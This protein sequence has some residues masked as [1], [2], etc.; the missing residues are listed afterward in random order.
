MHKLTQQGQTKSVIPVIKHGLRPSIAK[1]IVF[2]PFIILGSFALFSALPSTRT[3]SLWMVKEDGPVELLT[4][5]FLVAGAITGLCL[6]WQTRNHKEK[7]FV[8]A[9][10]LLFSTGLLFTA[11]EEIAWGQRFLGFETPS[12]FRQINAQNELT[13]HNIYALQ[14]HSEFF[15]LAFGVGGLLGM[16]LSFHPVLRKVGVPLILCSWFLII[17]VHAS[18]DTYNDYF[19]IGTRFDF[20]MQR[21]S[22][23]IELLIGI[24][25]FLYLWL[26]LRMLTEEW[27]LGLR[28][29]AKREVAAA[30]LD[31]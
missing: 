24:S 4:F 31:K 21:S 26:N 30:E 2:F 10:Y 20:L 11:M 8:P 29:N 25:A 1:A 22:E 17:A 19:P 23:L 13:I 12:V 5:L 9:F 28:D 15:R 14:G 27:G 7:T 18:V 16:W 3:E 6:V